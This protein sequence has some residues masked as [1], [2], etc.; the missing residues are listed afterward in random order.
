MQ[1]F[2]DKQRLLVHGFGVVDRREAKLVQA[3]HKDRDYP[4]ELP[5]KVLNNSQIAIV[6]APFGEP[7]TLVTAKVGE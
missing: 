3:F 4:A 2:P 6:H 1:W 5:R 7:M